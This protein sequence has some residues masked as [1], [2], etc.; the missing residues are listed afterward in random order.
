M[1]SFWRTPDR[2]VVRDVLPICV[3]VAL[4]GIAYGATATGSG[5]PLWQ[6]V[7]LA[8]LVFGASSELLFVGLVSAGAAPVVAAVAGLLVNLRTTAYGMALSPLLRSAPQRVVGAHMVNDETAA[9]ATAQPTPYAA[10]R[11]FW[12]CGIGLAIAWP[13]GAVVGAGVGQV[14][15]DPQAWG[16]DAVFP[17]VIVALV[18]SSLRERA[19]L[20]AALVG[21]GVAVAVTPYV[22][23]GLAPALALVG[24]LAP[25]LA[26]GW[27]R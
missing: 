14:V 3:T 4:V 5:F 24:L 16:L 21:G 6:V 8:A 15:P 19:T 22:P 1:R 9:L 17:A 12:I 23:Q 10:R 13:L 20:V 26:R 18:L 7:A 25:P 2:L 11:A 27:R